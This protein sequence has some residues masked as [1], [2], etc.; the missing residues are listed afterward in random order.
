[1]AALYGAGADARLFALRGRT[2]RN[3]ELLRRQ[4]AR[5]LARLRDVERPLPPPRTA[6]LHADPSAWAAE[7][8]PALAELEA[9]LAAVHADRRRAEATHRAKQE[10][11]DR[12]DRTYTAVAGC[13]ASLYHLADLD[14]YEERLRPRAARR[15]GQ[16]ESSGAGDEA[17][18]EAAATAAE[19]REEASVVESE[20]PAAAVS[21]AAEQGKEPMAIA[22]APAQVAPAAVATGPNRPNASSAA[23]SRRPPPR[24]VRQ[25][26]APGASER[27]NRPPA[28]PAGAPVRRVCP[29]TQP[30]HPLDLRPAGG[31]A[32]RPP[33]IQSSGLARSPSP[34][35]GVAR[36]GAHDGSRPSPPASYPSPSRRISARSCRRN[37]N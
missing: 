29:P 6:W 13:L 18:I 5:V 25:T 10:A 33:S 31:E 14:S 16:A 12:Y 1:V 3:P 2:G 8:A 15:A 37:G 32:P 24:I 30:P 17:R 23:P 34:M 22:A 35:I 11:L 26:T 21:L 4:A 20:P 9:A 36:S 27:P 28:T 7:L 19:G